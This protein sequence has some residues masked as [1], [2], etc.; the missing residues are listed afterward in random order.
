MK[1]VLVTGANGFIGQHLCRKLLDSGYAVRGMCHDNHPFYFIKE[2]EI[3]WFPADLSKKHTLSDIT[4]DVTMVYHL[5]AIPRNDISKTW[6]DFYQVNVQGTEYLLQDAQRN[7]VEKFIFISTVEAAGYGNGVDPRREVDTSHPFN[8]YGKSKLE[9]ENIVLENSWPFKKVVLRLPMIYGPGTLLI[10][11]KLFGMVRRGFYPFIGN[12]LTKMEFCYVE[13]AV[14]AIILAGEKEEANGQL[15]Y[16]SDDH[17]YTIKDVI[18][19]IAKSLNKKFITFHIP[20]SFA[21]IIGFIFEIIAKIIPF[22]PIVSPYSKKPF[23]TRE[24][25]WWTTRDVNIV[26]IEKIVARLGYK[27]I[28][29]I[30][31]GCSKTVAWLTENYWKKQI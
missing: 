19:E 18:N 17:S 30:S 26:S 16:V 2:K 24:T 23:F 5:A 1:K 8:N 22:P 27:S 14:Y 28:Y 29:T 4:K 3:E 15:F 7:G 12:G 9:A 10:V 6:G 13:N 20:V 21:F 11:P 25:V 31:E